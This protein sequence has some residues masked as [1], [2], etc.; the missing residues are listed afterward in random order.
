MHEHTWSRDLTSSNSVT[1]FAASSC[2]RCMHH[3]VERRNRTNNQLWSRGNRAIFF[4]IQYTPRFEF[5]VA[6][7]QNLLSCTDAQKTNQTN[8]VDQR[9]ISRTHQK[10]HVTGEATVC[11]SLTR[12]SRPRWYEALKHHADDNDD[13]DHSDIQLLAAKR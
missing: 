2:W 9:L 6:K 8:S 3:K 13:N 12:T 4:I 5:S 1:R 7:E 10:R 11:L